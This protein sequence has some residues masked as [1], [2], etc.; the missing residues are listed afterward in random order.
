MLANVQKKLERKAAQVA[1]IP[2]EIAYYLQLK[3]HARHLP[4]LD[5]VGQRA[6]AACKREGVFITSL[7]E[8]GFASSAA[9]LQAAR[10]YLDVM[11][12]IRPKQT[13]ADDHA[14]QPPQLLPPHIFTM[15]DLPEFANWGRESRLLNIVENYIGLPVAFQGV[16]LRRDFANPSPVT[17]EFWHQDLEDRR[18]LKAIIYLTDVEEKDGPFE[19]IPRSEVSPWVAKQIHRRVGQA[20]AKSQAM[21]LTDAEMETFVPRSA[22]KRCTG[23]VGTVVL[24]D[25]KNIFHHG[26]SRRKERASL[27]YVY[28]AANPLR[29]EHC[30]QYCDASYARPE[31]AQ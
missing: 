17:T 26:K 20:Y 7:D 18:M 5:A 27:F 15:T 4:T 16:H 21:G 10:H 9:M 29:P 11:E 8:L 28:T 25:P 30:T 14:N 3:Q 22:W 24:M 13:F 23:P 31:L 6:V 1:Q 2:A 19:Y 12:S